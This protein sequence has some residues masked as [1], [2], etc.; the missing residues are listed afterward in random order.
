[1]DM[2]RQ[3]TNMRAMYRDNHQLMGQDMGLNMMS[4][5]MRSNMRDM[6][7]DNQDMTSN[8]MGQNMIGQDMR[9]NMRDMHRQNQPF[10]PNQYFKKDDFGNYV[11]SYNDQQSEKSEE[12]NNQ[13]TKGQYAYI[14]SNGVKRKVEYIADNNGFHIIK[15]NADPARIKRSS[16]PDLLHT[17]M[18]SVMDSSSLRD[19]GQNMNRMS[20]LMGRDMSPQMGRNL[21][22]VD[23][24]RYSNMMGRNMMVK[25]SIDRKMMGQVNMGLNMMGQENMGHNMIGQDNTGRNMMGRNIYNIMSNS[26]MTSDMSG[27]MGKQ[28]MDSNMMGQQDMT[29]NMMGHNIMGQDRPSQMTRANMLRPAGHD[30]VHDGPQHYGSGQAVS[31][32][33]GQHVESPGHDS[34]HDVLEHEGP[35]HDGHGQ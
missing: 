12:G 32:D 25:D 4:Q 9:S 10:G 8:M 15:D 3:M 31:D 34:Q 35:R 11:Y 23:Q 7:R 33:Q 26:G 17:R 24:Q 6:Y 13:F 2:T 29:V 16:E 28:M 14:M 22:G 20:N 30:C 18:T 5:D 27:M 21:M 1:M 19:D